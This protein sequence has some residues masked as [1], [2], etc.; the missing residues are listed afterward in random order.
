MDFRCA[1]P[2]V[3]TIVDRAHHGIFGYTD[4]SPEL[5]DKVLSRLSR[6]YGCPRAPCSTWLR[7]IPG[8]IGGLN[9]AVG[10]TCSQATDAV[11]VATPVYA[12]FLEAPRKMGARLI[13]VPLAESRRGVSGD[14]L[15]YSIDWQRLEAAVADPHTKLVLWCNPHNPTG[16]CW[17]R[18]ELARLARLCVEHDAVL[19][20]DEVW[21]D[22]PLEPE[23]HPFTSM[24]AL[25]STAEANG[26]SRVKGGDG[27][28]PMAVNEGEKKGKVAAAVVLD[29]ND[30]PEAL[31]GVRGLSER[32]IVLTSP[33]KT[34]NIA[35][36]CVGFGIVPDDD[37]WRRFN[38]AC[39]GCAD[40][41]CFGFAAA[42]TA[43]E[44]AECEA[45]RQR[46][47]RYVNANRA[48]AYAA[49]TSMGGIRCVKPEA[50]YLMWFD[51]T[52][53]LPPGTDA[54]RFFLA[55]GVGLSGGT[56]FG[57]PPGMCR[58]NLACRKETLEEGLLKMAAA[59][60]A[61]RSEDGIQ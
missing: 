35:S 56:P 27:E 45:W 41:S 57:A 22:L 20:S 29:D 61:L 21:G 38:R 24:L 18:R 60:D 28:A 54:L 19:C 4:P 44:H 25:L 48:Y 40:I 43:Y 37:L 16:R 49:L 46:V 31:A 51:A 9:S 1:Q 30:D 11:A 7:W 36:L 12:P 58:I 2:L 10:A 6:V 39:G 42:L 15:H 47:V 32:L 23:A 14:E 26:S 50:T 59:L 5:E 55:A 13:E 52:A 3:D 8:L 53:A 17:T 34:F 33:M